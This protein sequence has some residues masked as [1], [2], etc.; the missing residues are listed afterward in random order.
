MAA[1][2]IDIEDL[3]RKFTDVYNRDF[4]TPS[5]SDLLKYRDLVLELLKLES[6][7]DDKEFIVL[8]RKHKFH[9]K[10]S[11]LFHVFL[12][13]KQRGELEGVLVNEDVL[14]KT[15]QIK[16]CK[17][18]SGIVTV[19]IFTS[20]YPTYTNA[21][22][23]V[24][25]QD[26]TCSWNCHYCPKQPDMPRSYL[27]GEPA[28]LRAARN[29][30]DCAR[31]MWDRI[32]GL[33]MTG[34]DVCKIEAIVSGGTWASYP[35]EYRREFCRDL[36][37]A[38]NVFWDL[39]GV[40]HAF[41]EGWRDIARCAGSLRPRKSLEE[42]KVIN[43]S[44][45]C[46][47]V[48]F[49]IETRPDCVSEPELKLLRECGVTR[50]QLGIQHI[51]DRVLQGV[52]RKCPI[53]VAAA[54]IETLKRNCFK[55]DSHWMLNLPSASA[56]DDDYMLNDVLLGLSGPVRRRGM[57]EEYD[58]IAPELSTDTWKIYP[59]AVTPWTEIETWYK[60]GKYKPYDEKSM[61]DVLH[62]CMSLMFPWIRVARVIRDIPADY[63]YNE[64]TGADNTSMRQ[65]LD[66]GL[67][68]DGVFCWDIRN[69]EVKNK[70]WDGKYV[71][72]VRKYNASGGDEYFISAE[73]DDKKV[74][75][76]F[77]RLRLDDARKKAFEELEGAALIREL[78]VY[79][80]AT[81]VGLKGQHIQH[82]GLGRLLVERAFDIARSRGYAKIAVI[83]AEGNKEYYKA[84][85][86]FNDVGNFMVRDI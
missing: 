76:G 22:G 72:I 63:Q 70:D 60:E 68:R 37:Y 65:E 54:G 44:A 40:E 42:E 73:S 71:V 19:T 14:R 38:A 83:A 18:W 33:Y 59:T 86:G 46:R 67:K 82:R 6:P 57:Y 21:D 53:K 27:L 20:A 81:K 28:V 58:L 8:K 61:Y 39:V 12:K 62:K 56:A 55:I 50:V 17:S 16:G 9:K 7:L 29:D 5:E 79:G 49:T 52:N 25:K 23:V 36:Y 10:R 84:K 69:R 85:L 13:L 80:D 2:V 48:G 32:R 4:E 31:Q 51:D 66:D 75:Y 35:V 78:H 43:Q 3:N 47:I 30:F 45:E 15:L 11:F 41:D 1:K 26:F 77:V 74:L 34:H 24:V 64:G